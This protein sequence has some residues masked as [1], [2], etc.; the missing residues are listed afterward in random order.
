LHLKSPSTGFFDQPHL[1]GGDGKTDSFF[2]RPI[3]SDSDFAG[4][5]SPVSF[6]VSSFLLVRHQTTAGPSAIIFDKTVRA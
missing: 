5:E 4:P 1:A 2:C 6:E 3:M